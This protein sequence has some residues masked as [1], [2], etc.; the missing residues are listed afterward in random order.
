MIDIRF[1]VALP[2]KEARGELR[3]LSWHFSTRFSYIFPEII[4]YDSATY[5]NKQHIRNPLPR[6]PSIAL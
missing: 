1:R 4:F 6:T 5:N 3:A 2:L